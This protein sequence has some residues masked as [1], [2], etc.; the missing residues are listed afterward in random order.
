MASSSPEPRLRLRS[1]LGRLS[2]DTPRK[3]PQPSGSRAWPGVTSRAIRS[4]T[5]LRGTCAFA[6]KTKIPSS[7]AW[8]GPRRGCLK[9]S[10]QKRPTTTRNC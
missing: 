8:H 7:T 10:H 3:V 9:P 2:G 6:S 4:S 5:C 1:G